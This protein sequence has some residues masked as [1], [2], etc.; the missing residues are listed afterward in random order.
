MTV[1]KVRNRVLFT[2]WRIKEEDASYNDPL[3]T[4]SRKE[5]SQNLN[6]VQGPQ[7]M[8]LVIHESQL[9]TLEQMATTDRGHRYCRHQISP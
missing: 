6:S 2:M 3:T 4:L 8:V 9:G 7:K 5:K 1:K